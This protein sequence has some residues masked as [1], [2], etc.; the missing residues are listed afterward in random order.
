[1]DIVRAL[2]FG[3]QESVSS[4]GKTVKLLKRE[5]EIRSKLL[6]CFMLNGVV[7]M[8]SLMF[9]DWIIVPI[10][11]SVAPTET[12][13][14]I[15]MTLTA[16]FRVLWVLP[17]YLISRLLNVFWYQEIADL[18]YLSV[19]HSRTSRDQRASIAELIADIVYS[20]VVQCVFLVQAS[21]VG[22]IPVVGHSLQVLHMCLVYSLYAFEYVWMNQGLGVVRR[23]ALIHHN[24][25]YFTGYGAIMSLVIAAASN[26]FM[27]VCLF[28]LMFPILIVSCHFAS[29]QSKVKYTPLPLFR[30]SIFVTERLMSLSNRR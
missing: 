7:F 12:S 28:S 4:C 29:P 24:W 30:P 25:A 20:V 18:V 26:Y 19:R 17:L 8:F 11:M 21:L 13:H 10:V 27:G 9:F 1:M 22:C 16:V 5:N 6:Q 14:W 15:D 3:V 2:C 23:V